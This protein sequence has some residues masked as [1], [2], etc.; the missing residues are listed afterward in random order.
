MIQ[1]CVD[2]NYKKK[3]ET[4][5]HYLENGVNAFDYYNHRFVLG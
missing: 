2:F 1:L 3:V 5:E 4:Y